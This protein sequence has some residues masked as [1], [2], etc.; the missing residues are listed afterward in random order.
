MAINTVNQ[1]YNLDIQNFIVIDFNGTKNFIDYIGGVDITLTEEEAKLYSAYTGQT[2][3]AGL[4]HMDSTL[5]LTHMRNRTIGN[6]F[7]RTKRQRDTI[8]AVIKQV[9]SK[10]SLNELYGIVDYTFALVKTN[11]SATDLV[12]LAAS[13]LGSASSLQIESQNVPFDDAYQFGWYNGMSIISF[14]ITKTA[15]RLNEF[16]YGD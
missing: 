7:G 4:K 14:D 5:A 16:I 3:E 15:A 13:L 1:L 10:N 11:I 9:A 8:T 2:I 12:S 6:D